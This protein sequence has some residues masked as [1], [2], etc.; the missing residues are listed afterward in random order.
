MSKPFNFTRSPEDAATYAKW[1]RGMCIFYGCVGLF[2]VGIFSCGPLFAS[3]FSIGRQLICVTDPQISG[4][5][6]HLMKP[7]ASS[8]SSAQR[9]ELDRRRTRAPRWSYNQQAQW[10][11]PR[12]V[13]AEVRQ[14]PGANTPAEGPLSGVKPPRRPLGGLGWF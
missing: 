4:H 8:Q 12:Q 7:S 1:R 9:P 10:G 13:G 11:A 14:N 6:L 5:P 2:V 3:G